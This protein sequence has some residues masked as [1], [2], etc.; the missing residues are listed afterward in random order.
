MARSSLLLL[1]LLALPLLAQAPT[2]WPTATPA[3][4]GLNPAVLDSLDSEIRAG[5]YGNVDRLLVIRH[6][7][8]AYDKAYTHD[9][10]AIYGEDRKSTRLNSSHRL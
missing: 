10:A 7:K 5:R 6:G 2:P 4:V 9:Y 3:A 1:P 8:I